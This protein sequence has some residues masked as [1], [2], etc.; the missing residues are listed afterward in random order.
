MFNS[1]AL[2]WFELA[3]LARF[4]WLACWLAYCLLDLLGLLVLRGLL[5]L[6]DLLDLHGLLDLLDFLGLTELSRLLVFLGLLDLLS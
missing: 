3:W 2:A 5:T 1:L 6:L 4:T